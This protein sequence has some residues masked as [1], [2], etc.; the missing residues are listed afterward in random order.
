[1][2]NMWRLIAGFLILCFYPEAVAQFSTT[3]LLT[4][5]LTDRRLGYTQ[6]FSDR[7]RG[8]DMSMPLVDKIELRGRTRRFATM[9]HDLIFRTSFHGLRESRAEQDKHLALA[10]LK[11]LKT[12]ELRRSLIHDRYD[13]ILDALDLDRKIEQE[14]ELLRHFIRLDTLY[15]VQLA[16]GQ[17]A[18]LSKYLKNKEDIIQARLRLE[19]SLDKRAVVYARLQRDTTVLIGQQDLISPEKMRQVVDNLQPRYEQTLDMREHE[20]QM[21]YLDA[22]MHAIKMQDA[23]MVDFLEGRYTIRNDLFFEDRFSIGVGLMAPWRGSSKNKQQSILLRKEELLT[24]HLIS[25]D[26]FEQEYREARSEFDLKY[27][28]HTAYLESV[29]DEELANLR[30]IIRRSG[31]ISVVD[32]ETIRKSELDVQGRRWEHTYELLRTYLRLLRLAD[33]LAAAPLRDYL[34]EMT[35][36]VGE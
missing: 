25:R 5:V 22:S 18:D 33:A 31:R 6:Q 26:Y 20:M 35:P 2:S 17:D 23:K 21:R 13:Q 14:A 4:P 28:L 27:A 9:R 7:F 16:A 11:S 29:S 32:I 3:D 15:R 24:E 36:I 19:T 30:D 34:H 10:E 12:V 1:M 8:T